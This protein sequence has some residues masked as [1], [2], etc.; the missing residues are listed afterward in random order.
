MQNFQIICKIWK[1]ANSAK[2]RIAIAS[3]TVTEHY[4][5]F[6]VLQQVNVQSDYQCKWTDN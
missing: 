1:H 2:H 4:G 3:K 6:T 5:Y